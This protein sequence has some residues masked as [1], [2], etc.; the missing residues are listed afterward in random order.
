MRTWK[1]VVRYRSQGDENKRDFYIMHGR[2]GTPQELLQFYID[3]TNVPM[4]DEKS[5]VRGQE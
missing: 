1:K 2:K 3:K 4:E 5:F